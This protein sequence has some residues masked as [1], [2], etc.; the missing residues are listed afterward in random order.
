[1][2]SKKSF[3]ISEAFIM[4]IVYDDWRGVDEQDTAVI[5]Q[6][7]KD[8]KFME[9]YFHG[10]YGEWRRCDVA[11]EPSNCFQVWGENFI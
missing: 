10:E 4:P 11:N 5:E 7:L 1:M 9:Y 2:P 6:W 8:N 3:W